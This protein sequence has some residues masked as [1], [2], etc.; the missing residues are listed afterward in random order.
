MKNGST[1]LGIMPR[2]SNCS[3]TPPWGTP[4]LADFEGFG[5]ICDRRSR[6]CGPKSPVGRYLEGVGEQL[7]DRHEKLSENKITLLNNIVFFRLIDQI[8]FRRLRGNNSLVQLY[9]FTVSAPL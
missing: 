9:S 2:G 4:K 7:P 5:Q 8:F 6:D 3:P 1:A